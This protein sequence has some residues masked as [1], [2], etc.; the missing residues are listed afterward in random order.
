MG[1]FSFNGTDTN[2]IYLH[3]SLFT[4]AWC[5]LMSLGCSAN[6]QI[7]PE[8]PSPPLPLEIVLQGRVDYNGNPAYL[9]RTIVQAQGPGQ[10]LVLR[11]RYEEIHSYSGFPVFNTISGLLLRYQTV[12]EKRSVV[13]GTLAI[14][15]D[16]TIFKTYKGQAT[17]SG[18][19][20]FMTETL[21]EMRL[22]GL[23][24]VRENIE[25]QMIKDKESLQTLAALSTSF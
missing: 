17:L 4:I 13:S 1:R 21:S 3:F 6:L 7:L 8:M 12:G 18:R 2:A 22:R 25:S 15:R 23:L 14:I 16:T 10:K 24:A 19:A 9:P 5:L 20:D 11:Y